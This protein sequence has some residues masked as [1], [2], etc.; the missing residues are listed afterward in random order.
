MSNADSEEKTTK[1][2]PNGLAPKTCFIVTPIGADDSSIRRATN[3]LNR[4]VLQPVL[5]E[6]GYIFRVAHEISITG[7]IV[8]QVI[9]N[10]LDS[11][12]VIANLTGL[13]P[14]VMYELAVRHATKK[15]VISI[16]ENGTKLPFDILDDRTLFYENDM[17]GTVDLANQL[18]IAIKTIEKHPNAD[19]PISRAQGT[20]IL[21]ENLDTKDANRILVNRIDQIE[22]LLSSLVKGLQ[23]VDEDL[24][25]TYAPPIPPYSYLISFLASDDRSKTATTLGEMEGVESV[26]KVPRTQEQISGTFRLLVRFSSPIDEYQ[27]TATTKEFGI[28]I[29]NIRYVTHHAR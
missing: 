17:S 7:S 15:P 21:I 20:K 4:S 10:L 23:H 19:N 22:S 25:P 3:G 14:N 16:A 8:N 29:V 27:L 2:N 18:R 5:E 13:N 6:F 28:N 1:S 26:Q 11:D 9:S 12:L 24:N